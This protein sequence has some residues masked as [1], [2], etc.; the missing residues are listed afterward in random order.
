MKDKIRL[1]IS[2]LMWAALLLGAY[3]ALAHAQ[4]SAV[5]DRNAAKKSGAVQPTRV[6]LSAD[7]TGTAGHLSKWIGSTSLGDS[8]ITEN[9]SGQVGIGTTAPTSKLT[10]QGMI[11]AT[12]GGYKFPDG[13]IQTTAASPGGFVVPLLLSGGTA[14]P[15]LSAINASGVGAEIKGGFGG[16]IGLVAN[17]G[18]NLGNTGGTGITAAGGGALGS[19]SDGGIGLMA[20][21]GTSELQKGGIAIFALCGQRKD[22]DQSFNG[23]AGLF[24]GD[25]QITGNLSKGGGSFKID[26]PLDPANKYLYHSFVESPDMMNIYNGNSK[27]DSNGEAVVELPEWFGTLNRDFRYTLTAIVLRGRTSTSRTRFLTIISGLRVAHPAPK[28]PGW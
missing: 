15:I 7:G 13:T 1:T 2:A 23:L 4:A 8:G 11:E 6:N 28:F 26:H 20:T 27:L 22:S 25:V 24:A 14:G 5:H 19:G 16:S 3:S 18:L 10:V 17:G 9:K 12:L 21:G